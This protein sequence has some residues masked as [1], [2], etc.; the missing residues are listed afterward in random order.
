MNK[1]ILRVLNR[2]RGLEL[3]HSS[4]MAPEIYQITRQIFNLHCGTSCTPLST[5]TQWRLYQKTIYIFFGLSFCIVSF[6]KPLSRSFFGW[7]NP[8]LA[9]YRISPNIT[10]ALYTFLHPAHAACAVSLSARYRR[11]CL[12]VCIML[13]N[14]KYCLSIFCCLD[15]ALFML[16]FILSKKDGRTE[17]K[18]LHLQ[19]AV[20]LESMAK[21]YGLHR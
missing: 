20:L 17:P 3:P 11:S 2:V 14:K 18:I 19:R 21:E 5:G 4:P 13:H 1:Y 16:L 8:F 7:R 6:E 12:H 10:R 15:L 9:Y